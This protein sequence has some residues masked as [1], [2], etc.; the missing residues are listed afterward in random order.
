MEKFRLLAILLLVSLVS[1]ADGVNADPSDSQQSSKKSEIEKLAEKVQSFIGDDDEQAK[2]YGQRLID[3]AQEKRD[4]QHIGKG[5]YFLGDIAYYASEFVQAGAHYDKAIYFLERTDDV[6]MLA[7]SYSSRGSIAYFQGEY[8]G[9]IDLYMKSLNL[10]SELQLKV[11]IANAY[12]NLGMTYKELENF[13][14]SLEYYK[15]AL[16]LNNEINRQESAALNLNGMAALYLRFNYYKA[17]LPVL[18]QVEAIYRELK[19]DLNLAS[20]LNNKAM[21]YA[22]SEDLKTALKLYKE[23]H[24]L[25]DKVGYERGSINALI[26]IASCYGQLKNYQ[27]AELYFDRCYR[28]AKSKDLMG[29]YLGCL[30]DHYE[31]L[32]ER[33]DYKRALSKMV[34]MNALRDSLHGEE[35]RK[36]LARVKAQYE[37]DQQQLRIEELEN[38]SKIEQLKD[39]Q[40]DIILIS[41]LLVIGSLGAIIIVQVFNSRQKHKHNDL[42][43]AKN[44]QIETRNS[45]VIKLND[46]LKQKNK[47]LEA[48]EKKL[49]E[50]MEAKDRMMKIIVKDI[51][52]PVEIMHNDAVEIIEA[53]KA[54][55]SNGVES[56]AQNIQLKSG[57]VKGLLDGILTWTALHDGKLNYNPESINLLNCVDGVLEILSDNIL[58]MELQVDNTIDPDCQIEADEEMLIV[59][60]TNLIKSTIRYSLPKGRISIN[61]VPS[62]DEIKVEVIDDGVA[63][64]YEE[65]SKLLEQAT[66]SDVTQ[67][68]AGVGL[69]LLMS[70]RLINI[71]GGVI[72]VEVMDSGRT[73]Y[74]FTIPV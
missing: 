37:V 42:L 6:E 30:E 54:N 21:V 13:D 29:I 44:L 50:T 8:A 18:L 17:A 10:F 19:D 25:F 5:Y 32:R 11:D 49:N 69:G 45:K 39:R 38:E 68:D 1:L 74:Y 33:K 72:G 66:A 58:E 61:A 71:H 3:L 62:N 7:L 59:V 64:S 4:T 34:E 56:K 26:G 27:Q 43:S 47:L 12:H 31:I 57:S 40:N 9:A 22:E 16:A 46:E 67:D 28:E 63:K 15:K 20:V 48:S 55:G 65:K 60:F 41:L 53:I 51:Y 52:K 70:S 24:L 14:E 36:E 23:A 73:S 35:Q 2:V